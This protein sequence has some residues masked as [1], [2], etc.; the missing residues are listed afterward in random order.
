LLRGK[1][2]RCRANAARASR[3]DHHGVRTRHGA[4]DIPIMTA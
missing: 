4:N 2:R 1:P 3:H